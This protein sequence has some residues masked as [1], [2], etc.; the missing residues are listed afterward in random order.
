MKALRILHSE[1]SGGWGG[2]EHRTLKEMIVLRARGHAVEVVCPV[3]A[4]LGT[5]AKA[6]GF[7]VHHARMKAGADVSSMLAIRALL[8]RRKFDVLNT[9]SGHAS[10]VPQPAPR[11]ARTP[12]PPP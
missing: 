10:I 6:E 9:D 8:S 4:R 1:S 12:L 7:T 5:R 11:L 3:G 2:Q